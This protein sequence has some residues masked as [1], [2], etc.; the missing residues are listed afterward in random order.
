MI[1]KHIGDVNRK[2]TPQEIEMLEALK[3]RPIEFD[4]DCPELTKEELSQFKRV[5]PPKKIKEQTA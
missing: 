2:L 3:D 5:S 1:V 4:E